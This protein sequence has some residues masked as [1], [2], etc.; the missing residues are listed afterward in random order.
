MIAAERKTVLTV[1]DLRDEDQENDPE[2]I[3][4]RDCSREAV[5]IV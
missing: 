1:T 5:L 4:Y 3:A 2:I